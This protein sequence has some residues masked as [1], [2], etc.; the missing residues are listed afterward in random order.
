M[1]LPELNPLNTQSLMTQNFRGLDTRPRAGAGAFCAM[2]NMQGDPAPLIATRQRRGLVTTLA[3]P[4]GLLAAGALAWIDGATLYY[5]GKA[6]AITDLSLAEDMLPKQ[7][8]AMGA[9]IVIFPDGAYYNTAD[10]TDHG[11]IDRLWQRGENQSVTYQLCQMDGTVYPDS[12]ITVAD[13]EPASPADGALWIDTSGDPH[14]LKKW[15]ETLGLW[16]GVGSV[17]VKIGCTGIGAGLSV[18]DG[19]QL[20]GIALTDEGATDEQKR[21]YDGLNTTMIITARG[22][23]YIVVTGIIDKS[24]TQ[25]TGTVRADRKM[26]RMQHVCECNNRLWGCFKGTRDGQQL[27]EIYACALGDFKN[28]RKYLGTSQDSY[29]VSVGTDGEFTGAITHM[30]RPY[31]FKAGCVHKLYGE[32]PSNF[33]M[34][35]TECDGVRPGCGATLKGVNGTLYYLSLNGVEAFET[36]PVD[37]SQ[38]LG[39]EK[40][41]AAA[42]G[43]Y[44]G[45]YYISMRGKSGDWALY[46]YDTTQE[47][48]HREDGTHA[49]AFARLGDELY[50]LCA[51]GRLFAI[52]GTTGTLEAPL[53]WRA[54]SAMLGYEYKDHKYLSR[55]NIRMKL[56]QWATCTLYI[57]YDSSGIWEPKG[58]MKGQ[59]QVKTYTLPVV[60]RRCDH[61]RLRLEGDG[62][63]Q[64]YSIA[65]ILEIGSDN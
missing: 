18:Q 53:H 63:A 52:N 62:E 54:D 27:N 41:D 32:K 47:K 31:F 49:I 46:C 50:M 55:F 56:G 64:I 7:M 58:H 65:R 43:E 22:D 9:Y 14:L 51:D 8:V 44:D 20:S 10:P 16:Q 17:Y 45:K 29:A 60:P 6:T 61:L 59:A 25:T 23:D 28:W 1:R 24:S 12:S 36:L 21:Q 40:F 11:R 57:E 19:V 48:W 2:E 5:G 26:P 30:S 38:Q 13:V 37:V 35:Y 39:Q 15:V 34:Q 33:E 3:N 4:Q 42:A